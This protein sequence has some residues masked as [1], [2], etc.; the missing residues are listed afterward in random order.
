MIDL[1]ESR[2]LVIG[3]RDFAE[4]VLRNFS[5]YNLVNKSKNS[6]LVI[7]GSDSYLPGTTFEELYTIHNIDSDLESIVLKYILYVESALKSN[8]S[9]IVSSKYGVFTDLSDDT[10][11]NPT[12]Y[13]CRDHYSKRNKKRNN[14]LYK[15]KQVL[16]SDE[17]Y[18]YKS[19]SLS[20]YLLKHNHVPAWILTTSIPLGYA[21]NWYDILVP[22]DKR[23]V[24]NSIL[25]DGSV[26]EEQRLEYFRTAINMLRGFRNLIAHGNKTITSTVSFQL[27]SSCVPLSHGIISQEEYNSLPSSRSGLHA[28]LAAL[29]TLISDAHLQYSLMEDVRHTFAPYEGKIVH[30]VPLP[31]VFGLPADFLTRGNAGISRED[32]AAGLSNSRIDA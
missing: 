14:T 5:Y 13:L 9:Y 28:V 19:S 15:L 8:L 25:S 10:N 24:C 2:G 23:Y 6:F 3:D 21:I 16:I 30:G 26:S 11:T 1:L 17:A 7:P 20:H 22:D 27:S 4:S 12:D 31:S 29:Y 32:E 18:P